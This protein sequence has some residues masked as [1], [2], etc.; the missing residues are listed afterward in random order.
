VTVSRFRS[1]R[2]STGSLFPPDRVGRTHAD[3]V[4][5]HS[6]Q[7]LADGFRR[8][9]SI[10][11]DLFGS[12]RFNASAM[13]HPPVDSCSIGQ[14]APAFQAIGSDRQWHRMPAESIGP[15][16]LLFIRGHWCPYC[17][18]FL[19]KLG[20]RADAVRSAFDRT[21]IVS[22]E[23]IETS[24]ML[25]ARSSVGFP[26]LEDADGSICQAYRVVNRLLSRS[27]IVPHPASFIIDDAGVI[28]FRAVDRNYKRRTSLRGLLKSV[29]S[30]NAGA[31]HA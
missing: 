6:K 21:L 23:P 28:R 25:A 31:V 10:G 11:I 20:E 30:M 5:S 17:R 2:H 15:T 14:P 24:V 16:L 26:I 3:P 27:S 8:F 9:E 1:P 22:P 19:R 7:S 12:A 4:F 29:G 13:S 18:R